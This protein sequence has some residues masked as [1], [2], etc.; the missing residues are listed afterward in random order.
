MLSKMLLSFEGRAYRLNQQMR[1]L[2][3]PSEEFKPTDKFLFCLRFCGNHRLKLVAFNGNLLFDSAFFKKRA[4]SSEL[5]DCL[6][7][8]SSNEQEYFVSSPLNDFRHSEILVGYKSGQ[9]FFINYIHSIN[10]KY[11]G[12]AVKSR[13]YSITSIGQDDL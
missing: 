9:L 8:I 10:K 6:L 13:L 12:T 5:G 2:W 3:D 4:V 1:L 11:S 7:W